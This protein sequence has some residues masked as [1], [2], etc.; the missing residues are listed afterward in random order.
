MCSC[1]TEDEVRQYLQQYFFPKANTSFLDDILTGYPEDPFLGS[2]FDTGSNNTLTPEN[3]RIAA[4]LGDLLFQAPRRFLLQERLGSADAFA[5]R[6]PF[7]RLHV[8]DSTDGLLLVHKKSK[9]MAVLGAV[10]S[11]FFL[12][13]LMILIISCHSTIPATSWISMLRATLLTH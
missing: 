1:S 3:K 6:M 13:I 8:Y 5:F 10:R 11:S 4:I 7:H 2:P 12:S 9:P